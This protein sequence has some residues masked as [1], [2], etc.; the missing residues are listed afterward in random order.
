MIQELP[1][2]P[3][4]LGREQRKPLSKRESIFAADI[5]PQQKSIK[6]KTMKTTL[7]KLSWK[8]VRRGAIYCS[9]GC[10]HGCTHADYLRAKL[11]STHT[12]AWLKTK[13]W[14]ARVWENMDWHWCLVNRL[15]G[16]SVHNS[17]EHDGTLRYW[18]MMTDGDGTRTSTGSYEIGSSNYFKD[19]NNAVSNQ[20]ILATRFFECKARGFANLKKIL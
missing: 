14:I 13:G 6:Y 8:P 9:S 16:I 15:C 5:K 2:E 7:K 10:G 18:C 11:E 3:R 4:R 19:P 17:R 12:I 1:S 20:A